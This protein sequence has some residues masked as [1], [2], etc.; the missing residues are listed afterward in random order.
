MAATSVSKGVPA[1]PAGAGQAF[2]KLGRRNAQAISRLAMAAAGRLDR[3]GRVDFARLA[4]G[5]A[6]PRTRRFT[7]VEALLLGQA[8]TDE[9]L[10]AAGQMAAE[11]MISITGRR[12]STE[13]K[14]TA[15]QAL[16]ER[17]LRSALLGVPVTG[18]AVA[19]DTAIS[20]NGVR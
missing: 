18:S 1:P 17:A 14:E 5:A 7:E 8:P 6:M 4:P 13:Y 10:A 15:I 19:F 11:V 2:I 9:L 12:W 16:A 20:G 3:A